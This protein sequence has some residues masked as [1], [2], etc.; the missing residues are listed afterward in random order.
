MALFIAVIVFIALLVFMFFIYQKVIKNSENVY[1]RFEPGG[2]EYSPRYLPELLDCLGH[3]SNLE[4]RF[5][6]KNEWISADQLWEASSSFKATT[7]QIQELEAQ[8]IT[9]NRSNINFLRAHDLI[10]KKQLELKAQQA[11][12]KKRSEAVKAIKA[13]LPITRQT[14]IKLDDLGLPYNKNTTRAEA[15]DIIKKDK[16][17]KARNQRL[18]EALMGFNKSGINITETFGIE[19]ATHLSPSEA[20]RLLAL[21]REKEEI[22]DVLRL[23]SAIGIDLS[24]KITVL[25]VLGK[26]KDDLPLYELLEDTYDLLEPF[27]APSG[28]LPPSAKLDIDSIPELN[29]KLEE[30][31]DEADNM[32]SKVDDRVL[33][34]EDEYKIIGDLPEENFITFREAIVKQFMLDNW[35]FEEDIKKTIKEHFPGVRFK[36]QKDE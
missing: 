14:M 17:D 3:K 4:G 27:S 15:Q 23:I 35:D 19:D 1:F 22:E 11:E 13:A 21:H 9:F 8:K 5:E 6:N 30:A 18:A 2:E 26:N 24:G 28:L 32:E 31:I 20:D 34:L 16:E 10:E 33:E 36:K 25:D 12:K 7:E 29:S